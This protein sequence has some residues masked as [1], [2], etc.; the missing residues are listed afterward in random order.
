MLLYVKSRFSVSPPVS[1]VL[2]EVMADTLNV[3]SASTATD[4]KKIIVIVF[5]KVKI[6]LFF[7][8][9]TLRRPAF[10]GPYSC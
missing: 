1:D 6:S 4:M 5:F 2:S 3:A 10:P 8:V 9:T 7:T